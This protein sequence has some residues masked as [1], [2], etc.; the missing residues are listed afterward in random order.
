MSNFTFNK[1]TI[2]Y[3]WALTISQILNKFWGRLNTVFYK[4]KL[5]QML[6][7]LSQTTGVLSWLG[8]TWSLRSIFLMF[9]FN[10]ESLQMFMGKK[11]KL[12]IIEILLWDILKFLNGPYSKYTLYGITYL[13]SLQIYSYIYI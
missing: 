7:H 3:F 9:R 12:A 1:K 5:K 4:L 11:P 10:G 13:L 8:I 6:C 2:F